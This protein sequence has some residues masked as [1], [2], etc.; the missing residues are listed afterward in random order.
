MLLTAVLFSGCA[1]NSSPPVSYDGLQLVPDTKF[2]TVYLKPDTNLKQYQQV[3]VDKCEVSFRKNW[4]RDQNSERINL[5]N[6]VTQKDVDRIK[7]ALGESCQQHFRDE[8][9]KDPNYTLVDNLT[10]GADTLLLRP[11]IINL[12]IN[13]PDLRSAGMTRTYTTSSG[14]MTLALE[15]IDGTTNDVQAR[16]IDRARDMD[17]G[18]LSWSNSVTNKAEADR[19]LRRWA[20][21]LR[22][23]LD[24]VRNF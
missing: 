11:A 24:K 18:Y 12:D 14:E 17:D 1:S 3:M 21:E 7:A 6:R 4:L 23:G 19:I 22:E 16:V 8:L 2:A 9:A 15:L 20:K 13:A 5:T 10:N